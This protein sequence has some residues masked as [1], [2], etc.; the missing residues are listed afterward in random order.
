MLE[1]VGY[2]TWAS[3]C[4]HRARFVPAPTREPLGRVRLD[5]AVLSRFTM[6]AAERIQLPLLRESR[7]RQIF[8]L[9]RCLLAVRIPIPAWGRDLHVA[10]T[11]LSAFSRGDGTLGRQVA[12]LRAWMEARER[13]GDPFVLG[14]D[15]NLL[16]PGDDPTRLGA[17]ADQY[18]DRDNPIATLL[19]RFRS[20]IPPER[21]LD[22]ANRTYL[23]WGAV[24]TERMLDYL[25]VSD[26]IEVIDAHPVADPSPVSDHLPLVASL[27]LLSAPA[28]SAAKA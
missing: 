12:V 17:N 13:D 24:A 3:A 6:T 10:V 14:G 25:F 21:I 27:R 26:G 16:P 22:P 1:R 11:H 5:L 9:Q 7:L 20:V 15:L 23:P 8:N 2:P 28:R 19:P 4:Y 18:A